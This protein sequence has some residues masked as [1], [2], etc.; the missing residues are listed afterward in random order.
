MA[1]NDDNDDL[2]WVVKRQQAKIKRLER[3]RDYFKRRFTAARQAVKW[4]ESRYRRGW[5]DSYGT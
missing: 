1:E 4:F 5:R 3:Q 2:Q